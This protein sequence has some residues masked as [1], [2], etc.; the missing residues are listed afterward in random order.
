MLIQ[1]SYLSES[2]LAGSIIL[3][4]KF[5]TWLIAQPCSLQTP[6]A[7]P[8]SAGSSASLNS[9][10][11]DFLGSGDQ[12]DWQQYDICNEAM[13]QGELDGYKSDKLLVRSHNCIWFIYWYQDSAWPTNITSK[14]HNTR[15]EA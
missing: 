15:Y 12:E 2:V 6:S 14:K 11:C 4:Q 5:Q 8:H 9:K 10:V 7:F 3:V 13:A 1:A